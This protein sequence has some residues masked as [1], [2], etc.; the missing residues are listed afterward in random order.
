MQES[1]K[2]CEWGHQAFLSGRPCKANALTHLQPHAGSALKGNCWH[3]R[4]ASVVKKSHRGPQASDER[5]SQAKSL[6]AKE[7]HVEKS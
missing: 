7:R 2:F 4:M 3:C 1:K 6:D 5:H